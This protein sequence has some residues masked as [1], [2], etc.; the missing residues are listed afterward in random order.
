MSLI[1]KSSLPMWATYSRILLTPVIMVTLSASF[2]H[3][4]WI[5][6]ILF[7]VASMTDWLDG[8]LARTLNAESNM[9]KFMDP[10]ADKILILGCLLILLDMHRVGPWPVALLLGRDIYIGGLRSVAAA[11]NIIISAKPLGKW[12]TALQMVSLPCLF[13]YDSNLPIPF[14]TIVTW[15]LWGAVVLSLIS[16]FE[17]MVGYHRNRDSKV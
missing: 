3:A 9:G 8:Y 7:I 17:Y 13:I 16:G 14:V 2:R 5:A 12:K 15:L 1:Q 4:E 10:I 11:N 6:G